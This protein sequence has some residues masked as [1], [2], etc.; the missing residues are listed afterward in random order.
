MASLQLLPT[1]LSTASLTVT[2]LKAKGND[3]FTRKAWEEADAYYAL[4]LQRLFEPSK[5]FDISP[6]AVGTTQADEAAAL[7]ANRAA[8]LCGAGRFA[9][10]LDEAELAVRLR[11][12]WAKA[13]F[14]RGQALEGLRKLGDAVR[15]YKASLDREPANAQTRAKVTELAPLAQKEDD[16]PRLQRFEE[17][18]AQT[19]TIVGCPVTLSETAFEN[20]EDVG[21]GNYT[22][23]HRV[24]AKPTGE[25]F[26]M[27]V[28]DKK[29]AERL[30]LRHGNLRAEIR[31]ERRL[32]SKFDS[33]GIV[34]LFGFFADNSNIYF[35]E[36]FIPGQELW[37][38]LK[39]RP[40]AVLGGEW[41]GHA[42]LWGLCGLRP[43]LAI[44]Y[45]AQIVEALAYLETQG[46]VHRDLKPENVM[47][48][49]DAL[50]GT[51][52]IKLIDFGTARDAT[53]LPIRPEEEE[54]ILPKREGHDRMPGSKPHHFVGTPEFMSP[55]TVRG[56]VA[57]HRSDLW[58]LGCTAYQ[59]LTGRTPF[60]GASDYLTFLKAEAG[61]FYKPEWLPAEVRA[62]LGESLLQVDPSRRAPG[63]SALRSH[64]AFAGLDFAS[65]RKRE[66]PEAPLP[67]LVE[68]CVEQIGTA[69]W[70]EAEAR[71]EGPLA[72]IAHKR[73][74]MVREAA[75]A[76]FSK[77][78]LPPVHALGAGSAEWTLVK[79]WLEQR[80]VL[81]SP[82]ALATLFPDGATARVA[83]VEKD[84]HT[85]MGL[86]FQEESNWSDGYVVVV[87][88]LP[89]T[90]IPAMQAEL[91]TAKLNEVKPRLVVLDGS[92]DA[93]ADVRGDI[94]LICLSPAR[95][96]FF[97]F[98]AGAV[99]Y[100][101]LET[102]DFLPEQA[103]WLERELLAGKFN[104]RFV[105]VWSSKAWIPR[106]V[107]TQQE[108]M[109]APDEEGLMPRPWRKRFL[110]LMQEAGVH[111]VITPDLGG[112][113]GPTSLKRA[114]ELGMSMSQFETRG[115]LP[116]HLRVLR[117]GYDRAKADVYTV[118]ELPSWFHVEGSSGDV[119]N[120]GSG[121]DEES[122]SD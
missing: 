112:R 55:E 15:A 26:A 121:A 98:W 53:D 85:Y 83:R 106:G 20:L 1:P 114:T 34:R 109:D 41:P 3:A 50:R 43:S 89:P 57:D 10:A 19:K 16:K 82:A 56:E 23:V 117:V 65:F 84:A 103:M 29:K 93:F 104:A 71:G 92:P 64:A 54:E 110:G 102:V 47:V 63:A 6:P 28:V 58:A 36:E 74:K 80:S 76:A 100:L 22:T 46:V 37:A 44:F 14:R 4:A 95:D 78:N 81:S 9:G 40:P 27:K 48:H 111:V 11:P 60:K 116:E 72:R 97:S 61:V 30:S 32:L 25:I 75:T 8:A 77:V 35:L 59:L 12:T 91:L 2:D 67:T 107:A 51:H 108:A 18:V 101:V 68:L 45:V 21:E 99:Q 42:S 13:H 94:P 122:D 69:V 73:K 70:I 17:H 88:A 119:G 33:P 79:G 105:V 49:E 113:F 115:T 120:E 5:G 7:H 31:M 24:R 118:E 96:R 62:L 66:A 86:S 39:I 87:A 52:R 38:R 90:P